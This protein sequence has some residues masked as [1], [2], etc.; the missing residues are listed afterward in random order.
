VL[1][2]AA[3]TAA[4]KTLGSYDGVSYEYAHVQLQPGHHAI[5]SE[6]PFSITVVGY[7]QDVSFG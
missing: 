3:V 5:N 6:N 1:D 2:G 4:F 7:S